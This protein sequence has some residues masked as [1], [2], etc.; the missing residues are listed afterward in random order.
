MMSKVIIEEL[1][2]ALASMG[3]EPEF[4]DMGEK[5][6]TVSSY[7]VN[8]EGRILYLELLEVEY[9]QSVHQ[10]RICEFDENEVDILES[11]TMDAELSIEEIIAEIEEYIETN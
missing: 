10:I 9:D 11:W 7:E 4:Y 2:D 8:I 5:F 6:Q 3:W 1:E